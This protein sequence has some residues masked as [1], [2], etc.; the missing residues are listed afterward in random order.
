MST[1]RFIITTNWD[2]LFEAAYRQIGQRYQILMEEAD[3]P[4]FNFDQ[5][6]LLKIHG[7][8]DR[9][10]SLVCTTADYEGYPQ[11]HAQLLDRVEDLLYNNTVLFVGHGLRDEHLRRLLNYIRRRRGDLQRRSYVVGMYDD[12]RTKLLESRKMQVITEDAEVF[13]PALA[14]AAV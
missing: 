8:I 5:H 4:M 6:N 13:I 9:P 14:Q 7:S 10:R 2:L 11:T 1:F 12:V 3:A